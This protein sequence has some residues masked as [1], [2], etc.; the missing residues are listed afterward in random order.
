MSEKLYHLKLFAKCFRSFLL[1]SFGI[2]VSFR[3]LCFSRFTVGGCLGSL[4]YFCYVYLLDVLGTFVAFC[5]CHLRY[6]FGNWNWEKML[7]FTC[8]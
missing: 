3:W 1:G 4:W 8:F 2:A 6:I 7:T 5:S